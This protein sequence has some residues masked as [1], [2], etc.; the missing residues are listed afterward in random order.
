MGWVC[1]VLGQDAVDDVAFVTGVSQL[2]WGA[3][4]GRAGV[5]SSP[6]DCSADQLQ[7][8]ELT[9]SRNNLLSNQN[10][11]GFSENKKEVGWGYR[12]VLFRCLSKCG[13]VKRIL[14][15]KLMQLFF[16]FNLMVHSRHLFPLCTF[17]LSYSTWNYL[18]HLWC[19]CYLCVSLLIFFLSKMLNPF[20]K[21]LCSCCEH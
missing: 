11:L 18:H 16:S 5:P 13:F 8:C 9:H 1:P 7:C 6:D 4:T 21:I 17:S 20:S 10:H 12:C 3:G 19:F 14:Y 2:S 15:K